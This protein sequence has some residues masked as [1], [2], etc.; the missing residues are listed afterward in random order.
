MDRDITQ[1]TH[2]LSR[3][4]GKKQTFPPKGHKIFV[5]QT[6]QTH[7]M[8]TS[9][10]AVFRNTFQDTWR[11]KSSGA[12]FKLGINFLFFLCQSTYYYYYLLLQRKRFITSFSHIR[13]SHQ[14]HDNNTQ[15]HSKICVWYKLNFSCNYCS[16][17]IQHPLTSRCNYVHVVHINCRR[18]THK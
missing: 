2:L 17:E 5:A 14:Q 18:H 16:K 15:S 11:T 6:P 12:N 1:Q 8:R 10:P 3:E 13:K 9:V 4:V 7:S